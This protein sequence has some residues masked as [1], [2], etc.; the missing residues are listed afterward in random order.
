M[1]EL[2]HIALIVSK[3]E[4]LKFYEKLGFK[5]VNRFMRSYDTVVFMQCDG[6]NLE[7]FIDP[8]HPE[9][10]SDPEARGLRHIAITVDD[11]EKMV[12]EF[13]CEVI[14]T[15]FFG[16]RFTFAKDPDNQPI[17]LKEKISSESV[18]DRYI[19]EDKNS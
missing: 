18:D 4:N 17:E 19:R 8:K 6:I 15:D 14:S 2:D 12:K 3:E 5:E 11:F 10:I 1:L 7:I 16:T 9:R 13:E